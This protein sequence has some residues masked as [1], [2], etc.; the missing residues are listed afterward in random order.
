MTRLTDKRI[1]CRAIGNRLY[2]LRTECAEFQKV[3]A[4]LLDIPQSMISFMETGRIAI[5]IYNLH[6]LCG[7]YKVN[8][9]YFYKSLYPEIDEIDEIEYKIDWSEEIYHT[10]IFELVGR[11]LNYIRT[12]VMKQ[13]MREFGKCLFISSGHQRIYNLEHSKGYMTNDELYLI[14]SYCKVSPRYFLYDLESDHE[15]GIYY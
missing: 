14:S 13:S 1:R 3:I 5:N 6:Q 4:R 7:H 12:I 8:I 11:R 2:T 15:T 10:Q 9:N